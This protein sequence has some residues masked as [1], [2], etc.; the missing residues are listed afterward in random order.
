MNMR[1]TNHY[2][3]GGLSLIWFSHL[4]MDFMLGVWPVYKTIVQLDLVV[5][6]LIASLGLFIGEGL[7]LFFGYLS[8]K[9]YQQ[10]LLVLGIG[11]AGVVPFLSYIENEWLLFIMVL[12]V[13]VGSGAFH[14]SGIGIVT[15]RNSSRKS[16]FIA[17]FACGGMVG[18]AISQIGYTF[19]YYRFDGHIWFLALP[20]FFC[21]V[22]C[23]FFSFP[24]I[25]RQAPQMSF[26][27]V[28]QAIKPQ[29]FKLGLLYI[30]HVL[31]QIV[32][33]S[34]AFL[35]PD[36]LKVKGYE[37]WFCLGG[38]YFFFILGSVLT[39]IP[40]GYCIDKIGYRLVLAV[41]VVASTMFLYLFLALEALSLTLPIMLLML[42]GGTMGVIVPVVVAGGIQN[43][44]VYTRSFVSALYMGGTSCIAAIGPILASLLASFFDDQAPVIAL[45][46][47]SPLL[48]LGLILIY[49]LPDSVSIPQQEPQLA[50][51]AF[52]SDGDIL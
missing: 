32:L 31:L 26:K 18:A 10:K 49:Y 20:I 27:C 15:S 22:G 46:A 52:L 47:L 51:A 19:M 38:G 3:W 33:L 4:L 42:L 13:Y 21:V 36:I 7:Q 12:C 16:L 23:A 34:F 24:K 45:Q 28:L 8:D 43:V 25:E 39:S 48:I 1:K 9:G 40:I 14:P 29:K 30:I 35:L 17:F 5:A 6:G 41:I 37:E 11:L 44:P 50:K 2:F